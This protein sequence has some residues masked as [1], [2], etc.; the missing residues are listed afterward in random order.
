MDCTKKVKTA[1]GGNL[2]NKVFLN[3]LQLQLQLYQKETPTNF[4]SSEIYVIFNNTY[5]EEHL[6]KAAPEKAPTNSLVSLQPHLTLIFPHNHFATSL[7]KL[8]D[9]PITS[10]KL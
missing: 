1:I 6:R 5:F 9:I 4:F 7:L 10:P 8:K 2:L 3:I